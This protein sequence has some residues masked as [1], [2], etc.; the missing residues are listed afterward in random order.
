[1]GRFYLELRDDG[2][3]TLASTWDHLIVIQ[4]SGH[5][6][7]YTDR[8]EVKAGVLT[9]LVWSFAWVFY[10]HRQRRWRRLVASGFSYGPT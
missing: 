10:L 9:L 3:G 4:A 7:S 6:C 8:I 5:G 1:M 2:R